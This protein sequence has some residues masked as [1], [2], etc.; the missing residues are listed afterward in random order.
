MSTNKTTNLGLHSWVE[1]DPVLMREFNENFGA[2]DTMVPRFTS[3]SYVGTGGFGIDNPTELHFDFA[4]KWLIVSNQT[5]TSASTGSL[6]TPGHL[7]FNLMQVK[8]VL[9]NGFGE[10]AEVAQINGYSNTVNRVK[11]SNEGKTVTWWQAKTD[12]NPTY[13]ANA[14]SATHFYV[15]IG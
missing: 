6:A 4:P 9:D 2:I 15:A 7:Q 14:T 5:R 11:V 3:G 13:Q 8:Y 10:S 12:G 1:T